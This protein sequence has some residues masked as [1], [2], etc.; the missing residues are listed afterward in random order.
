MGVMA[1][2]IVA[3]FQCDTVTRDRWSEDVKLSAVSDEEETNKPWAE[4]TP[5]GTITMS[6]TNSGAWGYFQPG[7]EY[8][9]EFRSDETT[10]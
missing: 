6:I 1:R 4:A 10:K 8:F 7:G 2:T 9:L 5:S 3:K